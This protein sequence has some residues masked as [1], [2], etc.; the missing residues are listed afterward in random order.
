MA[1]ILGVKHDIGN[2][3]MV[4]KLYRDFHSAPK[5]H[6]LSPANAEK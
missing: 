3:E 6:E 1:N 2:R 4:Q 5:F